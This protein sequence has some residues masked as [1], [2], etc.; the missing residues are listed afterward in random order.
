[1]AGSLYDNEADRISPAGPKL[2]IFIITLAVI[3][4][5]AS[6]FKSLDLYRE[7]F[8]L[9]LYDQQFMFP[10]IGVALL[11]VFIHI[12]YNYG[13]RAGPVPWYDWLAGLSGFVACAY[14]SIEY[15]RLADAVVYQPIDAVICAIVISSPAGRYRG[16]C[17]CSCTRRFFNPTN[18]TQN[19]TNFRIRAN[20]N[21]STNYSV[22]YIIISTT[23]FGWIG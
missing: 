2:R 13:K 10:M 9:Q 5:I 12:P 1:M 6:I 18:S 8:A 14:L 7:I 19:T 11:L 3:L 22:N 17:Y 21:S 20:S 23:K 4:V 15:P 16:S